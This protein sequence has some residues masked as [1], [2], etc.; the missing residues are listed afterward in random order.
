MFEIWLSSL[1]NLFIINQ[2]QSQLINIPRD[3]PNF[4]I[5]PNSYRRIPNIKAG[6]PTKFHMNKNTIQKINPSTLLSSLVLLYME[7]FSKGKRNMELASP[8]M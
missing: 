4:Q 1:T 7:Q 3:I 6:V 8:N 2:D 5:K